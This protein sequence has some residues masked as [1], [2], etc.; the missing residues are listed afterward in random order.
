MVGEEGR[1]VVRERSG[2]FWSQVP[3]AWPGSLEIRRAGNKDMLKLQRRKISQSAAC[4][5]LHEVSAP[6]AKATAANAA[7]AAIEFRDTGQEPDD[8]PGIILYIWSLSGC[9]IWIR[10]WF[11][12][13]RTI[14]YIHRI[15]STGLAPVNST[16][17]S[18]QMLMYFLFV[19][20]QS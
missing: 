20:L 16:F 6:K 14:A 18:T 7:A 8:W 3:R 5:Y 1:G 11:S 12:L 10:F 15:C 13:C 19:L 4:T 2:V 9:Y 17:L